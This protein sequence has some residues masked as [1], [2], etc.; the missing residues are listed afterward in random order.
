[1]T[2]KINKMRLTL[3]R[4][5]VLFTTFFL[6]TVTQSTGISVYAGAIPTDM[7]QTEKPDPCE[8]ALTPPGNANGLHKRC[9][10]IG[11]GGGAAKGDFNG[12]GFADLAIGVP[13]EDVNGVTDVGAV[14]IIYG[15][16]TGLTTA[17]N[18]VLYETTF[19]QTFASGD[20]FGWALAAGDFN[21]DGFSDL[22]IGMPD[23]NVG[24]FVN[25]GRVL[26]IDGSA[27]GLR[28][29]TA[30]LLSLLSGGQG[31]A[32]GALVWA[33][34]NGDGFGDLAVGI[35]NKDVPYSLVIN[36][37]EPLIQFSAGEVQVFYGTTTGL[38]QNGAQRLR[39]GPPNGDFC[40]AASSQA[41]GDRPTNGDRLGSTLAAGDFNNDSFPD[42]V[43]GVPFEDIYSNG[44]QIGED[45]G[46]VH[47]VPGSPTGLIS[48][49]AQLLS[50]D[51]PGVEGSMESG[52]Q[53]G[54]TLATGDFDG[55][56]KADLAV[57]I[58]FEDL[59]GNTAADGGAVQIF[60]GNNFGGSNLVDP[61]GDMFISQSDLAGVSVEAGD[62]FGWALAVG[63]FDGD[64]FDDLAI[65]VPGEDIG[66]ITD[67]GIVQ[68]LYGSLSGP[69]LTRTQIWHQ[70]IAGIPDVAEIG[71]QFGFSL[72]AWNYGKSSHSDLAIGVPLE[73]FLSTVSGTQLIDAGAVNVIYGSSTGLTATDAQFWNQDS[74]IADT[75]EPGDHFGEA[76]Y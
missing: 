47:I 74:G 42:L 4:L 31:R 17:A 75:A 24:S 39:Q 19:G 51:T 66:P 38:T 61:I 3:R 11:I 15:S 16:A 65:G 2:N 10:A 12:D 27:N 70:D 52:D 9:D 18:Q 54:R 33:D 50:Q 60:F 32:G 14:N 64:S 59:L 71:D 20:H 62:R 58:P 37:C 28:T 25:A 6:I 21:G 1:M 46:V 8:Q 76:I 57:G 48:Q 5:L 63:R 26:L 44:Y 23:K 35:P 69:S 72:S 29:A 68:V 56:R 53:F 30:R 43:I 45:G 22:A 7:D 49:N 73:D 67:A 55:D 41:I 40:N 36:L 13:R 34:F